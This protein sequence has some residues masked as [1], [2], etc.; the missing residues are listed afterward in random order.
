MYTDETGDEIINNLLRWA[1]N[2]YDG[3]KIAACYT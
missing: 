1:C 2:N 3:E